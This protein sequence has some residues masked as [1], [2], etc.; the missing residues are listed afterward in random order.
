MSYYTFMYNIN[1]PMLDGSINDEFIIRNNNFYKQYDISIDTIEFVDD[2]FPEIKGAYIHSYSKS[3]EYLCIE[4]KAIFG[5][6]VDFQT[7]YKAKII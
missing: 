3:I 5:F 7:K 6:I 2:K 1:G 4:P